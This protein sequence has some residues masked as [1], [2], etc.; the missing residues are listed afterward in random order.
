MGLII[1]LI[2]LGLVLL[3][4]EILLIPGIGVAGILGLLSMGGSC[5]LAFLEYDTMT[6][7]IVLSI[8]LVLLV[9]LLIWVLRAKTW[10]RMS[11]K[12]NITSKAVVPELS[13]YVGDKGVTTTRL[14]PMGNVRFGNNVLEVTSMEGI[15]NA[16]TEV[17]VAMID[18]N[19]VLVKSCCKTNI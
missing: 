7:L 13:V 8:I 5:Y 19:K 6:G 2:I 4:A 3:L 1:A 10:E 11:L 17:V 16:G 18:D 15:I 14:A 12:T 9:L